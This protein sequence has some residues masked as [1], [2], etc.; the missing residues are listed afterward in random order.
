MDVSPSEFH[1]EG[2]G[3]IYEI[4]KNGQTDKVN[5]PPLEVIFI[6]KHLKFGADTFTT[7]VSPINGDARN[8][9]NLIKHLER[10]LRS[11]SIES[12]E[13]KD[14]PFEVQ[15]IHELSLVMN[16]VT[17]RHGRYDLGHT[18]NY[19]I[20]DNKLTA[21]L[22][23]SRC[24]VLRPRSSHETLNYDGSIVHGKYFDHE[25]R[26]ISTELGILTLALNYVWEDSHYVA[27]NRATTRVESP[28]VVIDLIDVKCDP[29]HFFDE[30]EDQLDSLL[31]LLS[32]FSREHVLITSIKLLASVERG[33]SYPSPRRLIS[34]RQS[35]S[36]RRPMFNADT[37]QGKH[38]GQL[39][40]HFEQSDTHDV[41]VRTMRFIVSSY[42]IN[43]LESAYFL[44]HAAVEAICKELTKDLQHLKIENLP[45]S[46]L[47][48]VEKI[49]IRMD[50]ELAPRI[51]ARAVGDYLRVIITLDRL[52]IDLRHLNG[53]R[54]VGWEQGWEKGIKQAFTNRNELF[55]E[56]LVQNT[57][58]LAQD[59]RRLQFIFELI[60]LKELDIELGASGYLY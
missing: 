4:D 51:K 16:T 28:Q 27:G 49:F 42:E 8:A 23:L 13:P 30:V 60:A 47:I 11:I 21:I 35:V 55:H 48:A 37:F 24:N 32:F 44:A 53:W 31:V 38:F 20:R 56:G 43:N 14:Y 22:K 50:E 1:Y 59:L 39:L 10:N 34:Q 25:P 9:L 12:I 3:Y 19:Q 2:R 26:E 7:H 40:K 18:L 41:M 52:G 46:E 5:K 33:Y 15:H 58:L 36:S 6:I 45:S 54:K 57:D 29:I 17:I